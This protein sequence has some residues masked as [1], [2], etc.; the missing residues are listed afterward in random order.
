MQ[1]LRVMKSRCRNGL[2]LFSRPSTVVK[3]F[4]GHGTT[5]NPTNPHPSPQTSI[6]ATEITHFD[7]L[8]STWWD[9]SGSSRLLHLMNPLRH[10]FISSCLA[11]HG[12]QEPPNGSLSYLDIGCGGGIFAESA[13]RLPSTECVTALDPSASVITVA[14]AHAKK[15]PTLHL[16][17]QQEANHAKRPAAKLT[18]LN[19]GIEDFSP[20][21]PHEKYDVVTLFEVVEHVTH[22]ATF[23]SSCLP[24]VKPGGWLV[25]STIARTWTSWLTTKV[26]AE[27]VIGLVPK[28]THD[29]AKYVQEQELRAWFA[30]REEWTSTMR[31]QGVIYV[32]GLGW[33]TV[34]GGEQWGNYFFGAR[35]REQ[36]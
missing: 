36:S 34:T 3:Q 15:D 6:D 27:D 5:N 17:A 23:L 31:S 7:A 13:A 12:Q 22:P 33:Q 29:W 14:R 32:P 4:R 9:P 8:A 30:Q 21:P 19:T 11:S 35:R 28:G 20:S 18:Y 16:P 25:L 26:V 1:P 2:G 24:L 10:D